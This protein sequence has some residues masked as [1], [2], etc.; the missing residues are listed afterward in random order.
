MDKI[1]H[2]KVK[3]GQFK[4]YDPIAFRL[5]FAKHEG[6]DIEVLVRKPKRT[7]T[8]S[9]RKYYFG[10]IVA[11]IA[12]EMGD[13]KND[14]HEA[15]K[16]KFLYDLSGEFPKVKSTSDLTTVEEEEYHSEIRM[17]AS[18]FLNMYIPLPNEVNYEDS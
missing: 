3:K 9:Q 18:S 15:L 7:R 8:D 2:G 1:I 6:Q 12:E 14:V 4:P 13:N 17:W 16:I 11:L 5:Q 10:V